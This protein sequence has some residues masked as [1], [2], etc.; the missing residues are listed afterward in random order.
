MV[1][2]VQKLVE[3]MIIFL[4]DFCLLQLISFTVDGD[5]L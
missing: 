4:S 2:H 3:L 5:P 1:G